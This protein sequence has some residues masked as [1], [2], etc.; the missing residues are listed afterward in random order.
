MRCMAS[1]IGKTSIL[2]GVNMKEKIIALALAS[3]L[4]S[5]C[6]AK[7][8]ISPPDWA[9]AKQTSETRESH[10]ALAKHYEEIANEMRK[11]AE[12]EREQLKHYQTKPYK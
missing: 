3:A 11:D 7:E 4:L 1:V 12:E 2:F 8:T 6:T 10:N 9:Q 5:A